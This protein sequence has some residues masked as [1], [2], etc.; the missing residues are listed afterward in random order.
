MEKK[1]AF[2]VLNK[3]AQINC[4]LF[5]WIKNGSAIV[6]IVDCEDY[7]GKSLFPIAIKS[8]CIIATST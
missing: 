5:E 1:K 3:D 4:W 8:E 7:R 2:T 6:L